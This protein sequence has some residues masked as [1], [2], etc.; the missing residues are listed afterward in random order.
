MQN[1]AIA[2]ARL[3]SRLLILLLL[4]SLQ[5][6][7]SQ[8]R[9]HAFLILPKIL[10]DRSDAIAAWI[11]EDAES[12][13][14]GLT[15]NV[16]KV[17]Y[18]SFVGETYGVLESAWRGGSISSLP[19]PVE[20]SVGVGQTVRDADLDVVSVQKI[21]ALDN[22]DLAYE[23]EFLEWS[24]SSQRYWAKAAHGDYDGPAP[25]TTQFGTS[26]RP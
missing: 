4:A 20:Y 19:I 3:R 25:A 18:L 24:A 6:C 12:Y 22:G 17:L 14:S 21:Y 16:R 5:G 26:A 15:P 8:E 2:L 9:P 10:P 1:T 11:K 13:R 23:F 7:W